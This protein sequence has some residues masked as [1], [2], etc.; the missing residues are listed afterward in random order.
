MYTGN[1]RHIIQVYKRHFDELSREDRT[2]WKTVRTFQDH[3]DIDAPDFSAMLRKALPRKAI[4]SLLDESGS[5]PLDQLQKMAA[6]RPDGVR[7]LFRLLYQENLNFQTARFNETVTM[8]M[9]AANRL[10]AELRPGDTCDQSESAALFYLTVR[11][12]DRFAFYKPAVFDRLYKMAN[13]RL[14]QP[15]GLTDTGKLQLYLRLIEL[16]RFE[17]ARDPD[18]PL[19]AAAAIGADEYPDP[20]HRILASDIAG[21]LKDERLARE[22]HLATGSRPRSLLVPKEH[23]KRELRAVIGTDT[24]EDLVYLDAALLIVREQEQQQ[25]NRFYTNF[26]VVPEGVFKGREIG[27][28]I[29]SV[30][31]EMQPRYILVKASPKGF[32]TPVKLL[33][34]EI[35]FSEAHS[36][37]FELC[38]IYNFDPFSEI[39]TAN[40]ARFPGSLKGIAGLT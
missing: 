12:P 32:F 26:E 16:L 20:D 39:M 19:M 6:E 4:G 37:Q 15:Q 30:A 3:W 17:I 14:Y 24:A 27:Y 21:R 8:F 1:I 5:H 40:V 7:R 33:P 36:D 18:L 13:V 2:R 29:R 38:Y 9:K 34:E 28:C 25:V 11:Y 10:F 22:L 35:A 23:D 31:R